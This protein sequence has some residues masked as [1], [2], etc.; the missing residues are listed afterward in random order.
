MPF[1][2]WTGGV[3]SGA[4]AHVICYDGGMVHDGADKNVSVV[5]CTTDYLV[6][7][8]PHGM[9]TVPLAQAASNEGTLLKAV[10]ASF[11]E[12][13][14]GLSET[15]WEGAV[16]HRLDTETSGLVLFA[17]TPSSFKVLREAQRSDLFEKHYLALTASGTTLED[18]PP[19]RFPEVN[20]GLETRVASR[21]RPFGP[22][23]KTVRPVDDASSRFASAK[24]GAWEYVTWIRL[25]RQFSDG[26]CLFSCRLTR[27]FRHQV[28]CH[29]AWSGHALVG[30]ALYGAIPAAWLHLTAVG[31]RFPDP[32]SG[33]MVSVSDEELES[34]AVVV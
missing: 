6:V 13:L 31:L 19:Y 3:R 24:A 14:Q 10:A 12:V 32:T 1:L 26:R 22:K 21:F 20:Q 5:A 2:D 33:R 11:P 7:R 27:G 25:E 34:W 29:L 16:L 30:D 15:P 9:P 23:G 17:R 8:K 4:L 18:A 28:R